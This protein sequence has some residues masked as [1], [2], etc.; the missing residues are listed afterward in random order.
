[1][2]ILIVDDDTTV[3]RAMKR[4]LKSTGWDIIDA[5]NPLAVEHLGLTYDTFDVV[6]TDW[7][8]PH[9]G[10]DAILKMFNP[11]KVI[12]HSTIMRPEQMLAFRVLTKPCEAQR[13]IKTI[14]AC[15]NQ[16]L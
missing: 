4:I 2:R 13:L 15:A 12:V 9:G 10:G 16:K 1:M 11:K 8:M 6:V 3:L 7:N 5:E 14:Q